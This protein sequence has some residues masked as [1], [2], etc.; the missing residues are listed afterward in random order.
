MCKFII[1]DWAGNILN[2]KGFFSPPQLC[3]PM[4]FDSFE[5]ALEYQDEQKLDAEDTY[6]DEKGE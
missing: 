5:C 2:F 3:V 6:I 4:E 1:K